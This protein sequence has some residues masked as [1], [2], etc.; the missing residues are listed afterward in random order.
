MFN[1]RQQKWLHEAYNSVHD[2]RQCK[3]ITLA[4]QKPVSA[5]PV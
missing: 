1:I 3:N 4:W 5:R 2:V